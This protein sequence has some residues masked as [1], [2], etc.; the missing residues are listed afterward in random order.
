MLEGKE[1]AKRGLAHLGCWLLP[2]VFGGRFLALEDQKPQPRSFFLEFGISEDVAG[3]QGRFF[4]M[5]SVQC[6]PAGRVSCRLRDC[7]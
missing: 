1:V 3:I 2:F 6:A 4:V 5:S 7:N